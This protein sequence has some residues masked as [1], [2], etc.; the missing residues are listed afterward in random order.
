MTPDNCPAVADPSLSD[1]DADGA[2]DACDADID[3]DG[4][5]NA[6]DN[7]PATV[8]ADQANTDKDGEGEACDDDDD[9]DGALD[10][11][12]NCPLA[13]N[14]TQ[15]DQDGDNV[16][17]VCDDDLDGDGVANLAD[18]CPGKANP[19]QVDVNA[20]KVGDACESDW[21][22]DGVLNAVDNCPWAANPAQTATDGDELG[23]ACDCDADADGIANP[24]LGCPDVVAKDNCALTGN[25]DQ[26]DLDNDGLGDACDGDLDGDGDANSSDCKP[27][28]KAISLLAKE[29][30][31]DIDD[32][33]DGAVDEANATGCKPYYFDEDGDGAGVTLV[34]CLCAATPPYS[35]SAA[36]DCNDQDGT[37][38]PKAKEICA[39][40]KDDNCNGSENDIDAV[41][42][43][44]FFVDADDDGYGT[45]A[46][47]CLCT[48]AG[49]YS[50]KQA[51]DCND[52]NSAVNPGQMEK[53][54][55][56]LDNNCNASV[57]ETGCLGCTTYYK[58]VDGD[59]FGLTNDKQCLS[60][61][62]SPYNALKPGDC[63][64]A[65]KAV[66]PAAPESCNKV[67]DDCDSQTDES[68]ATGCKVYYQDED[69]DTFGTGSG[70]C[71]CGP[72]GLMTAAT[73]KDCNDK[74]AAVNPSKAEICGNAKDD[75]CAGGETEENAVGCA[76]LYLDGDADGY[77]AAGF[78]CL[79]GALGTYTAKQGGDCNDA[80]AARAPNL[81]EKCQDKKDNDCDGA[82]DEENCLGCL[83]LYKDVDADGYGLTSDKK[84]LNAAAVPYSA[85]VG[86]DCLDSNKA[87]NPKATEAC[88]ALDDNC[89]GATDE[90]N[91]TGCK[92][93]FTDEDKDTFGIG[94]SK[95]FCAAG[96]LFTASK[97]GDCNDKDLAVNPSKAEV[98]GNGKDD[99]C[100]NGENDL[101]ATGCV[102]YFVDMDGDGY[103]VST[104]KC[105]C[106]PQG[107]YTAK[108]AGDCDD[109]ATATSPA[110]TE[111]CL[112]SKD[113]N[114]DGKIDEAGCQ[115]CTTYYKDA[116]QDSYGLDADKQ[117]LGAAKYPY[118]A[119][120]GGDCNDDPAKN[121][122]SQKPSAAELCN[123]IDDNCDG[124]T[125]PTGTSGCQFFYP[126]VDKDTY[127]AQVSAMCL[128]TASATYSVTKTGDCSDSDAAIN[129]GKAE[130]CDGKDNNCNASIDEGV[131]ITFFKDQDADT[132]GGVTT[133]QACTA[134]TGYAA[135]SG[136]CNDFNGAINPGKAEVCNDLDDDCDS[137]V[138][139]GIATQ[140]VYKDNDG[141]KFAPLGGTSM[142]KCNVPVGW[143]TAQDINADAKFDW[144]CDD[145]DVTTHPG[146]ADTCGDGKDND[147]NG[148]VDKLCYTACD[149][150]WPFQL[151]FSSSNSAARPVDLDGDGNY[152]VVVQDSF[153]FAILTT[154]GAPLYD[155]SAA[156][157]NFSDANAAYADVDSYNSFGAGTQGVEVI[158]ANGG[159]ARI[160]KVNIDGTVSVIENTANSV[161]RVSRN[162]VADF[163]YDGAPELVY[164]SVNDKIGS[165]IFRFDTKT[166]LLNLV[167]TVADP[168]GVPQYYAHLLT[169]LDGDG[170]VD[171]VAGNGYPGTGGYV[172]T[173]AW[174]G[175]IYAYKLTDAAKAVFAPT[176]TP[177]GTCAFN[178]AIAKLNGVYIGGI[179]RFGNEI[180][181]SAYYSPTKVV[182][183]NNAA[184][185]WHWRFGLDGKALAGSPSTTTSIQFP[186]DVDDDGVVETNG[187]TGEFGLWDVDGDG[188]PDQVYTAGTEL[189]VALWVPAKK[190]FVEHVPSRAPISSASVGLRGIADMNGDGR[191][192]V[193]VADSAGKVFCQQLGAATFVKKSSLPPYLPAHARTNQWDNYE[194]NTGAD[195]NADGM[196]DRVIRV[197]SSL[198]RKGNFY[199]YVSSATDK[200]YYVV[201]TAWGGNICLTAPK[202]RSY[203]LKVFSYTDKWNNASKAAGADGK[204]DGLLW[205]GTTTAG[206]TT[207]FNGNSVI[208]FRYGEYKF[209]I[210]VESVSGFSPYWPY[211][212]TAAK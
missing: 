19:D 111:K 99:N 110:Q 128:C 6:A 147:C 208:P 5:A 13:A 9:N 10:V 48:N 78:K 18:N 187:Y 135:K 138:D 117:C 29:I 188:Y 88:N 112:D 124:Q 129:P 76:K 45:A 183:Q 159:R 11:A 122:A 174:A 170:V 52:A 123:S 154:L 59:G 132:Y 173:A 156:V 126:D 150:A 202:G 15:T 136:D 41:G 204:V 143:T 22:S 40:G 106:A 196:P 73:A 139:E 84:C 210:G 17:N 2:G 115:G 177:I 142:K 119:Y 116:D 23:D 16:G 53:C 87:V 211:W 97:D 80:D 69:K 133:A 162:L 36:G 165:K 104:A 198:T 201:D 195:T 163:D 145:S 72:T 77:G 66:S 89:N 137:L 64:D 31:N 24:A 140:T 114:C 113:N 194:P 83:T 164:H 68:N 125:D 152:E 153:G 179:Y 200:D 44:A 39:N 54:A 120:L 131:L 61:A 62:T 205:T 26:K 157:Y 96:G 58:D 1:L 160:Y 90:E 146:A 20:N 107:N 43:K 30:C 199:S 37:V 149:G 74:D 81:G 47:Q 175:K 91:A 166:G 28:D 148:S 25:A 155:Y 127:G 172:E 181:A 184:Q 189:R 185:A 21:D 12:D 4:L 95:C 167:S 186:T 100:A 49:D 33:C 7:C 60:S 118:T 56:K 176:C 94:T 144:D 108:Q 206:G 51:G 169:D 57:D 103:G 34:M 130:V 203:S 168:D 79:C 65:L 101:S 93:F 46:S 105:T 134:P 190:A 109:T 3:G 212:I 70:Q 178:T 151:K 75:N 191:L 171:L 102:N 209:A 8:N 158:T 50:A 63:N 182:G 161:I 180:Q 71:A 32:N 27:A 55:D 86:G 141:D 42:C 98:C 192:D 92:V 82:I 193:T 38:N 85:A 197:P 35:A 14:P 67:D 207:C 121:G